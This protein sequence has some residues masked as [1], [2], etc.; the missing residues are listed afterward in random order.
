MV[1]RTKHEQ[2]VKPFPIIFWRPVCGRFTFIPTDPATMLPLDRVTACNDFYLQLRTMLMGDPPPA[3]GIIACGKFLAGLEPNR[4]KGVVDFGDLGES[5]MGN[6]EKSDWFRER[7]IDC[8]KLATTAN[9]D[10]VRAVL[11]HM[12]DAWLRLAEWRRTTDNP[13]W[14]PRPR[15]APFCGVAILLDCTM[16]RNGRQLGPSGSAP[17]LAPRRLAACRT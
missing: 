8:A 10:Q 6:A 12:A 13:D 14:T 17:F 9:D 2:Q 16:K 3:A 4:A 11:M 15:I 1:I 7:A 5:W